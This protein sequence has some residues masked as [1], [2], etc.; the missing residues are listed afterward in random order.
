MT[1]VWGQPGA[2]KTSLVA[3]YLAA[4]KLRVLWYQVDEGDADVAAFF[5][6]LGQAAPRRRRPLP[7]LTPEY[8]QG[9]VAFSRRYFRELYSR[10]GIPFTVVFDNYQEVPA[11]SLLHEVMREALAE[12][13]KG[14]RV[15][16][17]SRSEPPPAFARHRAQQSIEILDWPELRFTPAE[18]RGLVRRLAPGRWPRTTIDALY[19]SVDGWCAGLVLRLEQLRSDGRTSTTPG[20]QSSELL[21]DYFA[22]EIFKKTDAETQDVLLQTAFLPRVTAPM[23]EALTEQPTAGGVLAALHKQGYF[24]SKRSDGERTYE[25]HPLFREFLLSQ[26]TRIYS[27]VRLAKIRRAAAGLL[28]DA[29]R[30]EAAAGLLR[31][32]LDWEGLALLIFRH[33]QTLLAQ[34]RGETVEAWLRHIPEPMFAEMPWLLFW[35]G[36][37]S[38]GWRHADCQRDLERAFTA[39]RQQQDR[40][41][42]FVAWSGMIFSCAGG[43]QSAPMARWIAL[44]DEIMQEAPGFPTKGVETRVAIAMLVAIAM[45]QPLHPDGARWA[46]RA[47][48]LAREHPD[49]TL[50]T[51]AATH[52]VYYHFQR[53]D[54]P[55]AAAVVDE[56]RALMHARDSSPVVVV[57]AS[58]A[59]AWYEVANALPSY[60]RTVA[61]MLGL[62]QTTGMLYTAR[63]VALC[64]GIMGALSDGDL[65]TAASWLRELE[66]DVHG[67]GPGFRC[68]YH[69]F[70]VWDA[71]IRGD[72][73]RATSYQPEM[74][75]LADV[76]G[77]PVDELVAH[78]M[79]AQVFHARGED[80]DALARLASA[81]EIA[82]TIR[83]PYFEFM[84]RLTE[85]QLCLGTGQEAEGLRALE[86]AMALG[87]AGGFVNSHVW[88][89]SVMA[90]LAARALDASIE[91]EYVRGLVRKRGLVPP[92]PPV[93]IEAWPWPIQI[94][95]LGR[96]DLLREGRPVQFSRKVQRKPLALLKALIALGGRAVREDLVMDALWPDAEGDAAR[97]ALASALHRLRALLGHEGAVV[98]QDGQLS[99]DA[100]GCWVD[101]WAVE[102]LLERAEAVAGEAHGPGWLEVAQLARR[103]RE[104]Y[105]G[106]FLAG[107]ESELPQTTT[108]DNRL[109]RRWL[110]QIA[111]VARGSEHENPQEAADWYEEGL[112]VDPCA[113]D[114]CRG[115][116]NVYCRLGRSAEALDTYHRCRDALQARL[117]AG[118]SPETRALLNALRPS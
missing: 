50:R 20:R 101:V 3:S 39:F 56:M 23:A 59:V 32:A 43:G 83:S 60:R 26:A 22:G 73:A 69:W 52:R 107:E 100:R 104:L 12:I 51:M 17:I 45:R 92:S 48:E 108:L 67:L 117:G 2:G 38:M 102:R 68:W 96:F 27:P 35:R 116:M 94:F 65:E 86:R 81:Q 88:I 44:L 103:V 118:P 30:V 85:A 112:R 9:L 28:D 18:A 99:L 7:L 40:M 42:M 13:P 15:I 97:A 106:A 37:C 25:Y 115:L 109:R 66:R 95:T 64:A 5:Y 21:F 55:K 47:L 49:L 111:R 89:P 36:F 14:G 91:V 70:I 77:R 74:L 34:G 84:V 16:F 80:R 93:E 33:A 75:R 62:A 19:E 24:T 8:R 82:Q 105:R 46:E 71:L 114:L 11:D 78:L 29:G 10:F 41:G 110:R 53:G 57:N 113:E 90:R 58:M 54:L 4:R 98:R 31:D 63:D 79:S 87:R 76:D 61:E 6:Y 1:W 72:V